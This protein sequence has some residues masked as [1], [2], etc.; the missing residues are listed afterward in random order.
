MTDFVFLLIVLVVVVCF[1]AIVEVLIRKGK[2]KRAATYSYEAV[3]YE[4]LRWFFLA[5]AV[6]LSVYLF[7]DSLEASL[8]I[9]AFLISCIIAGCLKGLFI[10]Y[11]IKKRGGQKE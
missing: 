1:A 8:T 4:G 7:S 3:L 5:F 2:F 9:G 10:E 6:C 11:K